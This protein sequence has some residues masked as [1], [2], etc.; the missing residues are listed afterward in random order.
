MIFS[1]LKVNFYLLK[2]T[3]Y[4]ILR[5]NKKSGP[6]HLQQ[7]K[8]MG[9]KPYDLIWVEGKSA[10]WRYPGEVEEL[11]EF[12][13]FVEEQPFDRFYKKPEE[14]EEKHFHE[15]I[16]EATKLKSSRFNT[17]SEKKINTEKKAAAPKVFVS[18]P[19][20]SPASTTIDQKNKTKNEK[21]NKEIENIVHIK[22]HNLDVEKS[23][24]AIDE[25]KSLY[26]HSYKDRTKKNKRNKTKAKIIEYAVAALFIL[27]LGTLIFLNFKP[28]ETKPIVNSTPLNKNIQHESPVPVVTEENNRAIAEIDKPVELEKII[29]VELKKSE[30]IE[31]NK[32]T[33]ELKSS[34]GNDE[35]DAANFI[36]VINSTDSDGQRQKSVRETKPA[37]EKTDDIINL[38]S[39]KANEYKKRAFGG[40]ENLQLTVVNASSF[41]LDKI[42]VELQYLKPSELPLKTEKIEFSSVAPNGSMTLKIPDSPRGIKVL[43][44]VTSV[45]S[46]QFDK[47]TAGL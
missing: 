19:E 32:K 14:K 37:T 11:K 26:A 25:L 45:E 47:Y 35:A 33:N 12:A 39:V 46:T 42:I 2:M 5:N 23:E 17:F 44:K 31:K 16:E 22:D 8:E 4:L 18:M 15:I 9:M 40:I 28:S 43:Y 10:A 38:V 7:L 3:T 30:P 1:I 29:P 13:P 36:T 24:M 34:V 6:Y 20:P 41:I 27:T 21:T